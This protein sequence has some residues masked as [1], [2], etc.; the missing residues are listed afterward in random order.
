MERNFLKGKAKETTLRGKNYSTDVFSSF[1][2]ILFSYSV[3]NTA[4]YTINISIIFYR[5]DDI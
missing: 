5:E 2:S 4:D 3:N 1:I